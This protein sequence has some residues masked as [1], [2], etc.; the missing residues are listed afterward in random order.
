M[1]KDNSIK[2]SIEKLDFSH[3]GKM[4]VFFSDGREVITPLSMFPDIKSLSLKQRGQWMILDDQFFTFESLSRVYS[5]ADVL[6]L[7]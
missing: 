6:Q 5:M 1:C 3:R 7:Q 4:V 2:L